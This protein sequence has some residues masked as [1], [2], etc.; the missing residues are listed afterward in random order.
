MIA[1]LPPARPLLWQMDLSHR[2]EPPLPPCV[3]SQRHTGSTYAQYTHRKLLNGKTQNVSTRPK[4]E[5]TLRRYFLRECE[6]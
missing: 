1:S 6:T 5:Q 3:C 2:S 4:I